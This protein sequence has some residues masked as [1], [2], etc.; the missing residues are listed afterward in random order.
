MGT[1][2]LTRF[3]KA[4]AF[5]MTGGQES[6]IC[7]F[8]CGSRL[9]GSLRQPQKGKEMRVHLAISIVIPGEA[10]LHPP[11]SCENTVQCTWLYGSGGAGVHACLRRTGGVECG[12]AGLRADV[13]GLDVSCSP[14]VEE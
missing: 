1:T 13:G 5:A 7:L 4:G 9:R 12:R 14:P 2:H 3:A 8:R 10:R 6:A 11:L